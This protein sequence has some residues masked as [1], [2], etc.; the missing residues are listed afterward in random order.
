MNASVFNHRT[1]LYPLLCLKESEMVTTKSVDEL[2]DRIASDVRNRSARY[3]GIDG[4][5]G[6]G[7]T[8]LAKEISKRLGIEAVCLDD[9]VD[10][11]KGGYVDFLDIDVLRGALKAKGI[12]LIIEG[13]C[14]LAAAKRMGVKIDVHI[15]V[16]R[17]SAYGIWYDEEECDPSIPPT[18]LVSKLE[19]DLRKFSLVEAALGDCEGTEKEEVHLPE[20]VK[21]MVYYHAEYRPA[22]V[23]DYVYERVEA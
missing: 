7:K 5:D 23:A 12:P 21:E 17:M 22:E 3:I 15:Y 1:S 4:K 8:T 11:E 16:K 10:K 6:S 2:L 19:D 14:L 20:L 18:E 9:Y 13:V